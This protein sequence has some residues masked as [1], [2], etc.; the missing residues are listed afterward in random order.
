MSYKRRTPSQ[1]ECISPIKTQTFIKEE[2]K[3]CDTCGDCDAFCEC[4]MIGVEANDDPC[5][6]FDSSSSSQ[7]E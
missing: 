4:R 3:K 6:C 7:N 1:Y 2:T 5:V